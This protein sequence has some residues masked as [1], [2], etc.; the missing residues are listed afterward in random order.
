MSGLFACLL[1]KEWLDA[2]RDKR[3]FTAAMMI[4]FLGPIM[5]GISITFTVKQLEK[6]EPINITLQGAQQFPSLVDALAHNAIF[7]D[8]ADA[9]D[10]QITVVV[11]DEFAENISQGEPA[12]I[13]IKGDFSERTTEVQVRRIRTVLNAFSSELAAMRLM[14]RGIAPSV[15]SPIKIV[16]QDTSSSQ[17]RAGMILGMIS[18]F[19]LMSVF[20]AST[21]VAIDCSAGERERN[22][23]EFLLAQPVQPLTLVMAKTLNTA[24]F[25]LVG[26]ALTLIMMA[27]VVDWLPF[28]KLGLSINLDA[29]MGFVIWLVMVPLAIFAAAFQL[30]TSFKSK[31]F[32]EAQ[33]YLSMTIILPM[34]IPMMISMANFEHAALAWLPLTGQ[35]EFISELVKGEAVNYI[36][37]LGSTLSTLGLSALFIWIMARGLKTEKMIL[38][39]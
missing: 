38:G 33:S 25:S 29:Q 26:A 4:A 18:T 22:S 16:E 21:N 31:T 3:A 5:I 20:V 15:V 8:H 37:L 11:D 23:L 10:S 32:K 17:S 13:F 27:I 7:T 1:K 28:H 12:E 39:L 9:K 14:A 35:N 19:V 36:G 34:M 6:Q 2:I 24:F 30:I